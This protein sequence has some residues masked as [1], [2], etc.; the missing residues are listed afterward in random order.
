MRSVCN[1]AYWTLRRVRHIDIHRVFESIKA[2][3]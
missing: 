2:R 3:L 1:V